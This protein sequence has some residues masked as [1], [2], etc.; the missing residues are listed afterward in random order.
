MLKKGRYCYARRKDKMK[1]FILA[2]LLLFCSNILACSDRSSIL[3]KGQGVAVLVYH[4]ILKEN[5]N[6]KFKENKEVITP[7]LFAHQMKILHDNGYT[8]ITLQELEQFINKKISLPPKSVMITFDDGYLSNFKYAYPVLKKYHYK[9]VIF[10]IT[11]SMKSRPETFNPDKLNYISW[12]ELV[13]HSDVFEYAGHTD[14]LHRT[15]GTMSFLLV[16]RSEDILIDLELSRILLNTR[17]FAYPFG[18]YNKSTIRLVKEAGYRMAFTI[19]PGKVY[20]GTPAFEI[21]RYSVFS[22]TTIRQF[23]NMVGIH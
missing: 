21:P 22:T 13:P 9:A 6:R 20:P 3:G 7:E 19:H 8:T 4:H 12:N 14:R 1:K 18:Q 2:L 23:K 17:Y 15:I 16:K 5:E 11:S 10:P